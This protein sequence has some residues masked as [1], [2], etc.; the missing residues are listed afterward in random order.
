MVLESE[1]EVNPIIIVLTNIMSMLVDETKRIQLF[2]SKVENTAG[3]AMVTIIT[4]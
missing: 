2:K 3:L 1:K 4:I